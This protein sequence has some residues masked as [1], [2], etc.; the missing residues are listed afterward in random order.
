MTPEKDGIY[1]NIPDDEYRAWQLPSYSGLKILALGGTPAHYWGYTHATKKKTSRAMEFGSIA[2]RAIL[3][4]QWFELTQ[5]LPE[6]IPKRVG[7]KYKE[8]LEANPG[9]SYLPN[10]EWTDFLAAK[11]SAMIIRERVMCH[12]I[13]WELVERSK[14]EVSFAWTD[15][16]TGVRCKG[17]TDLLADSIVD[18]KTSSRSGQYQMAKSAY[19]TGYH[20]Q[21]AM[22]TDAITILRG[23]DPQLNPVRFWFLFIEKDLPHLISLFDG[24]AAYDERCDDCVPRG[25]LEFGRRK[26]KEALS[27]IK[28]C[29]ETDAWDG[30]SFEPREMVIPKYAG[31]EDGLLTMKGDEL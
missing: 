16:D 18:I 24:H 11:E 12:P 10:G 27:I 21:A 17:R 7:T 6:D 3:E 23:E 31:W 4:P 30:Y 22:Y 19:W 5:P 20:I 13:A 28:K 26:Y 25:Y 9:V 1:E 29:E 14:P 8:L 2:H 15:P